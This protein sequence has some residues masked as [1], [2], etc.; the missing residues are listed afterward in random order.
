MCGVYPHSLNKHI[1]PL[2]ITQL[3]FHSYLWKT[4]AGHGGTLANGARHMLTTHS[5]V[6]LALEF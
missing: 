3:Q 6:Q 2:R 5:G 4:F 1:F